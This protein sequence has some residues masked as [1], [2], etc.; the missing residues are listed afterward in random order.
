MK[1]KTRRGILLIVL[2][3]VLIGT[4][5]LKHKISNPLKADYF[6]KNISVLDRETGKIIY[7]K[8]GEDRAYPAS[9]TKIMTVFLATETLVNYEEMAPIDV[10]T[11][12]LM[13]ESNASMAG[14]YGLES[15]N[16]S[17]LLYGTMLASGG[18]AANSLAINIFGDRDKF[19]EKMNEKLE[20][21]NL[22]NTKF[23]N[24]EGLHDENQYTTSN[25]MAL[26]LNEALENPS[27]KTIFTTENYTSSKTLDHPEGI[28]LESTVLSKLSPREDFQIL[29][30]KSGTTEKAGECWA[31]LG[32]KNGREYIVVVMGAPLDG[33][34]SHIKDT[35]TI[36]EKLR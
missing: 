24:P 29:G 6:S 3:L 7:N 1:Y 5:K 33:E 8:N 2:V 14:F 26:L 21:L 35:I 22:K 4:S 27:F 34:K 17:D 31:T 25:D 16:Y 10:G 30:G 19:V 15:T 32:E 20:E 11:Y 9:L 28:K 36:Y 12:K 13:V 18:E 23:A